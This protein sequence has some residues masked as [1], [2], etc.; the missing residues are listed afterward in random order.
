VWNS[1]ILA[2]PLVSQFLGKSEPKIEEYVEAFRKLE[3]EGVD[4]R[5]L[6]LEGIRTVIGETGT[7]AMVFYLGDKALLDPG[8]FVRRLVQI[9]GEGGFV[10]LDG[11]IA[12]AANNQ[13]SRS[14]RGIK[15]DK[16]RS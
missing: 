10:F 1:F 12:Q 8:S 7:S 4:T 15:H 5:A 13:K 2:R 3:R 6:Y 9:F 16:G 14:L 11:M